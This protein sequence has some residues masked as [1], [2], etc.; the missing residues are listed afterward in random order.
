MRISTSKSEAMVLRL[1]KGGV[2]SPGGWRSACLKR[3]SSSILGSCS[4]SEGKMEREI[5]RQIG[6][7][8]CGEEG[9]E[10]KGEALYL[11]VSLCSYCHLW[12]WTLG[13][14]RKDKKTP[15]TSGR[16]ELSPQGGWLGAPLEI[17]E[18]FQACPTRRRPQGKTQDTLERLCLSG[19]PGN[20]S[21]SPRKSWRKCLG[22]QEAK[23]LP[24]PLFTEDYKEQ[25]AKRSLSCHSS[26]LQTLSPC[27]HADGP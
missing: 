24:L 9:A 25:E 14:D 6:A 10:S 15:D 3:R 13:N 8:R 2:P 27:A 11:P 12:S 17:G 21:E 1:E 22:S 20:A 19:W 4:R 18:V 5:D 7:D 16:N 23:I 26:L